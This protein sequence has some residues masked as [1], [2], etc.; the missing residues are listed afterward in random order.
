MTKR[1]L[2]CIDW[3][4]CERGTLRGFA[5]LF[6]PSLHLEIRD[7]AIHEKNGKRWAQ[8]PARPQ[9]GRNRELVRDPSGKVQYATILKFSDRP[10]ADAFS[11]AAVTAIQNFELGIGGNAL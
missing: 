4:P 11:R 10:T 6:L 9:L 8:L 5:D 3:R 2:R 7:I 1:S